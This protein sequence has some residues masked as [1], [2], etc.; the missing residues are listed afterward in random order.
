MP[1][2]VF[3][4]CATASSH[5]DLGTFRQAKES[6]P[7]SG[8]E[9]ARCYACPFGHCG[10]F[11]PYH[12]GIDGSLTDP[13]AITAVAAGNDV[14]ASDQLRIAAEPLSNEIGMLDEI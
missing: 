12:V 10:H 4:L 9:L 7:P 5:V 2:P 11:R 8:P 1:I 13:S 6:G 14:F 3:A